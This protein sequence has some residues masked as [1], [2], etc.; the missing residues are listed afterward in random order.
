M[1]A[2]HTH[3][4]LL[5]TPADR[6]VEGRCSCGAVKEFPA[7]IPADYAGTRH[8]SRAASKAQSEESK[9]LMSHAMSALAEPR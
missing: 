2:D 5:G 1:T 6:V 7:Y 9:A 3:R 8:R 4:W